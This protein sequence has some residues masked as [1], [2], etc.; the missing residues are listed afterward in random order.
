[1]DDLFLLCEALLEFVFMVLCPKIW[2]TF[3]GAAWDILS[4][5]GNFAQV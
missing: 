1:M 4:F 2:P 5:I 3:C